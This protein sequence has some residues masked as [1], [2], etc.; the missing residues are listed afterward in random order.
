VAGIYDG[1]AA[2][3]AGLPNAA[4]ILRGSCGQSAGSLLQPFT[5]RCTGI[6]PWSFKT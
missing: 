4:V 3:T 2:Q 1:N 6:L 5:Q